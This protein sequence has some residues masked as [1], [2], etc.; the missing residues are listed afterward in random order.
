MLYW[1]ELIKTHGHKY[2]SASLLYLTV[3]HS[4]QGKIPDGEEIGEL[5]AN[6]GL[7]TKCAG[8]YVITCML[9]ERAN[10]N[11]R[12]SA[13]LLYLTVEHGHVMSIDVFW[14]EACQ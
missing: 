12:I 8:E 4:R 7:A 13:S 14:F 10:Q 6:K 3:E 2:V 11:P 5:L 1:R 9:P